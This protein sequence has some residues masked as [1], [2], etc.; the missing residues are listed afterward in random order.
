MADAVGDGD[1]D[2]DS[3]SDSDGTEVITET[4]DAKASTCMTSNSMLN[5]RI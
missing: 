1:S 5:S 4:F 2:S 3:D